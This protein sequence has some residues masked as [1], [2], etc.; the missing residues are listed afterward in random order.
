MI[1]ISSPTQWS[2]EAHSS[3]SKNSEATKSLK[4]RTMKTKP[5]PCFLLTFITTI[6]Q[7]DP[8]GTAFTYQGRLNVSSVPANGSYDFIFT[9][10]TNSATGSQISLF[11][12]NG[13]P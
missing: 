7:A 3:G 4:A 11:P 9:L 1:K 10:Y 13:L 2:G 5:I 6:A 12:T 8:L